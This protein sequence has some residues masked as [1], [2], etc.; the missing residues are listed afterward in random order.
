MTLNLWLLNAET[1]PKHFRKNGVSLWSLSSPNL[2]PLDYT[3]WGVLENKTNTTSH[4]NIGSLKTATEEERNNMFEKIILKACKGKHWT[5]VSTLLGL[6]SSVY[7][8]LNHWR[9]NQQPQIAEQKLY[10]TFRLISRAIT[11]TS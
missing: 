5:A 7:H 8:D 4:P 3:I 9:S 11:R 1:K 2:N 10:D 6:I